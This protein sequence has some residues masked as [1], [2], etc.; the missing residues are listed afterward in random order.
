M[1][2]RGPRGLEIMVVLLVCKL[3]CPE[4]M[5]ILRGN[6]EC[7]YATKLYGF[8][9]EVEQKYSSEVYDSFM[10]FFDTLPLAA[11]VEDA[12]FLTHGG[13]GPTM[14]LDVT[15]SFLAR[16]NL[17]LLVRSHQTTMEGFDS[18]HS[19]R[20]YTVFSAPNYCSDVGNKGAVMRL[21]DPEGKY[22]TMV[23]F[24]ETSHSQP[25]VCGSERVLLPPPME[26]ESIAVRLNRKRKQMV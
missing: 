16:N 1:V 4:S 14:R 26:G 10:T 15:E 23:Q 6:H 2:D 17:S 25:G 19:G 12:I 11:V 24:H 5:H 3:L 9:K 7:R 13:I 21:D 20:G 8:M 18:F 22:V